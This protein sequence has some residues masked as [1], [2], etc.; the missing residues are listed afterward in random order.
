MSVAARR[1]GYQVANHPRRLTA[2][3]GQEH[4]RRK[5][6]FAPTHEVH[7]VVRKSPPVLAPN[8]SGLPGQ[9]QNDAEPRFWPLSLCFGRR[10]TPALCPALISRVRNRSPESVDGR[11]CAGRALT[12][13]DELKRTAV[14]G[15][16]DLFFA[17]VGVAGSNPVVRSRIRLVTCGFV[18]FASH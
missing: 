1:D 16:R 14:D 12:H 13:E 6:L 17:K 2:C 18:S 11:E 5:N 7:G 15:P 4:G 10:M 9:L 3:L 8:R